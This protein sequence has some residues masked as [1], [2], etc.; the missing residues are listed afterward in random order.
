L[1]E[2]AVI[3]NWN[4]SLSEHLRILKWEG[5]STATAYVWLGVII[6]LGIYR[7]NA[8]KDHWK[9]PSLGD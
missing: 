8:I 2:N 7:E 9:A 6:Y 3:D 4:T 1:L 5:L